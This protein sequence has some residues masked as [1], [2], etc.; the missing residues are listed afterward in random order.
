M[1]FY[2]IIFL[3]LLIFVIGIGL[4][5]FYIL[6]KLGFPRIGKLI[7]FGLGIGFLIMSILSIYEDELFSKSD[8]IKLLSEQD[9]ELKEDFELINNESMS[10]IGDY[11]H[12]FT[13]RISDSDR[14]RIIN[15]IVSAKDFNQ[16]IQTV[17]YFS[18]MDDYYNGPRRIKYY[19]TENQYIKELFEPQR[20]GYAPIYRKIEI[21]KND[22]ILIFEDID[23]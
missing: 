13:L 5:I 12:T 15:E 23:D 19:E 6:K 22:N 3:V 1:I 20:K 4:A 2:I 16:N 17:G 11:Y 10:G 9:I 14:E 18:D 7:A 8:A 21:D